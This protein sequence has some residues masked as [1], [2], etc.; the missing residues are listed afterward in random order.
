[1]YQQA[2]LAE[3]VIENFGAWSLRE[4]G[5]LQITGSGRMPDWESDS[6][7]VCL[8][9]P[10]RDVL[11]RIKAVTISDG[12][13]TIGNSAFWNCNRLMYADIPKGVTEIGQS[14]FAECENLRYDPIPDTVKAIGMFAFRSCKSL[15]EVHIPQG[16]TEIRLH[17][18]EGCEY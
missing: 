15:T 2:I 3:G 16:V 9:T 13:T 12:I 8:T 11:D 4:D 14:A 10:W 18:F 5:L 17:T 6:D 1:M 7:A